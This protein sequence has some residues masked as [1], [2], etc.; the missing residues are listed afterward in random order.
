MNTFVLLPLHKSMAQRG[1][2][3][4]DQWRGYMTVVVVIH[5]IIKSSSILTAV[6]RPMIKHDA[7]KPQD[8]L[9]QEVKWTLAICYQLS[10]ISGLDLDSVHHLPHALPPEKDTYCL[11]K[12]NE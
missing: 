2:C 11:P 12:G 1:A 3:K 6:I 7:D 5:G 4:H 8:C 10:T 9:R